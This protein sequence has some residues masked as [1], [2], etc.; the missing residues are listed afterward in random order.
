MKRDEPRLL[1]GAGSVTTRRHWGCSPL[2][3]VFFCCGRKPKREKKKWKKER[4]KKKQRPNHGCHW[5]RACVSLSGKRRL[6]NR[7][8]PSTH[9]RDKY[10]IK[11][12]KERRRRATATATTTEEREKRKRRD[13]KPQAKSAIPRSHLV[14]IRRAT[15]CSASRGQFSAR[16]VCEAGGNE[17]AVIDSGRQRSSSS[18]C[19]HQWRRRNDRRASSQKWIRRCSA[20]NRIT[21]QCDRHRID[22]SE[23]LPPPPPPKKKTMNADRTW[24]ARF[25]FCRYFDLFGSDL[26][27]VCFC[28][29]PSIWALTKGGEIK[30]GSKKEKQKRKQTKRQQPWAEALFQLGKRFGAAAAAAAAAAATDVTVSAGPEVSVSW[31][32]RSSKSN[33]SD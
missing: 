24:S 6:H 18:T 5:I 29:I 15:F 31:N 1:V 25:P 28:F 11:K 33:K 26:F 3:F 10:E 20:P 9:P 30:R 16:R 23:E 22:L 13:T 19:S 7:N 21:S 4:K 2:I 14:F 8:R 12:K 32:G 17:R 27:P